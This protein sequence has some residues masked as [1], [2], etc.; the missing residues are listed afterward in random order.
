MIYDGYMITGD[1]YGPNFLTF[2]LRLRENPGKSL[3]QEID[4][5]GDRTRPLDHSGGRE[6]LHLENIDGT[7][8]GKREYPEKIKKTDIAHHNCP[9]GASETRTRD[10]RICLTDHTP[11]RQILNNCVNILHKLWTRYLK[12]QGKKESTSFFKVKSNSIF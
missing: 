8:L 1:E 7:K 5:T 12:R 4:P 9:T 10:D 11:G 3:N 6:E 2:V